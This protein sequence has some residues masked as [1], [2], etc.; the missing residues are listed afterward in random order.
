MPGTVSI[1]QQFKAMDTYEDAWEDQKKDLQVFHSF[2]KFSW[3]RRA[4]GDASHV[5]RYV[6]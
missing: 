6:A 1:L 3:A 5:D 2:Q 4:I